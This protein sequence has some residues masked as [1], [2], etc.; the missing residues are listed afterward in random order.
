MRI[1]SVSLCNLCIFKLYSQILKVHCLLPILFLEELW[2][3][4]SKAQKLHT[5][6]QMLTLLIDQGL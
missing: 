3:L 4:N 1:F 6:K 5:E 2:D